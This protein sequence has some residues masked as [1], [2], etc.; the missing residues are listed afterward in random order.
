MSEVPLYHPVKSRHSSRHTARVVS[1]QSRLYRSVQFPIEEQLLR[2]NVK[3]FRGGLV[4]KA[5]RLL[6]HSTL[7]LGVIKK[8][9][10]VLRLPTPVPGISTTRFLF[11]ITLKPRVEEY[12]SL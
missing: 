3:R 2:R 11:C 8:R 5:D 10:R 7:G 12:T 1:C 6:H 4:F 9:R